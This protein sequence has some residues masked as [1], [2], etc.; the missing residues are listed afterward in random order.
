VADFSYYRSDQRSA[1]PTY[2][3]VLRAALA[4]A[5]AKG[6]LFD[7]ITRAAEG[8]ANRKLE[9]KKIDADTA[10]ENRRAG[11]YERN[12][13]VNEDE[14]KF[15]QS[16]AT[17]QRE[18]DAANQRAWGDLLRT[19]Y[20]GAPEE[21]MR[22]T[23]STPF[24]QQGAAVTQRSPDFGARDMLANTQMSQQDGSMPPPEL[25][26]KFSPDKV[27]GVISAWQQMHKRDAA[28]AEAQEKA[29]QRQAAQGDVER[30]LSIGK[31]NP[32]K[33]PLISPAREMEIRATMRS[34]PPKG[35][36]LARTAYEEGRNRRAAVENVQLSGK[37]LRK[38]I[39]PED[40]ERQ[41]KLARIMDLENLATVEGVTADD[42]TKA[43]TATQAH[44]HGYDEKARTEGDKKNE[45]TFDFG[46][47]QKRI[48]PTAVKQ[49]GEMLDGRFPLSV[50]AWTRSVA[51]DQMANDSRFKG[52]LGQAIPDEQRAAIEKDYY[53][54]V[55]QQV[56]ENFNWREVDHAPGRRAAAQQPPF[57]SGMQTGTEPAPSPVP[58][59]P[60]PT[61][62]AGAQPPAAP[63]PTVALAELTPEQRAEVTKIHKEKGEAEALKYLIRVRQENNKR[64]AGPGK[65][66]PFNEPPP[67]I[68][69]PTREPNRGP[70]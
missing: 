21:S 9:E 62:P 50:E 67:K 54:R 69:S 30:I 39:K 56:R 42:L 38:A 46:D 61:A 36:E 65:L 49:G 70:F 45:Q 63:K 59:T 26:A 5:E 14:L 68:Q 20:T 10:A 19:S 8:Y 52:L 12:A 55:A 29:R 4:D 44:I 43:L 66:N 24:P 40:P 31:T 60:A 34:D 32:A 11:I 2:D 25:L 57:G 37:E 64:D 15:R 53:D 58:P 51:L 47:G 23:Q 35:A 27:P 13:K 18:E 33:E 41:S 3:M 17:R 28:M 6:R 1:Q 16:E 48:V 22:A 7:G